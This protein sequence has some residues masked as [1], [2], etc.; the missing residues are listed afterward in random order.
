[1]KK[2]FVHPARGPRLTRLAA[3]M[4]ASSAVALLSAPAFGQD[5]KAEDAKADGG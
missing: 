5:K 4:A 2:T 1:M 3:L